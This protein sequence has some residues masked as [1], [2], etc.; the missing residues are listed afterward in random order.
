MIRRRT[1]SSP[2]E[3]LASNLQRDTVLL[4]STKAVSREREPEDMRP[5]TKKLCR[6]ESAA[7][8]MG[9]VDNGERIMAKKGANKVGKG[10]VDMSDGCG[11]P[12][13]RV[14]DTNRPSTSL[15]ALLSSWN[16]NM[17]SASLLTLLAP[18]EVLVSR[19]P[20]LLPSSESLA[21]KK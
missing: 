20:R 3:S 16:P 21:F 4:S 9:P 17:R 11:Q 8:V 14:Q 7:E 15:T 2:E 6:A 10:T 12:M 18:C 5:Q 13:Y 1:T 19:R